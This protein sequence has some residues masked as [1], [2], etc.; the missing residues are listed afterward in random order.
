MIAASAKTP[1]ALSS[2][3]RRVAPLV[4]QSAASTDDQ[5][6]GDVI[7]L[8]E[9]NTINMRVRLPSAN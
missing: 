7:L 1:D 5:G 2:L 3:S 4:A 6:G 9:D 8:V